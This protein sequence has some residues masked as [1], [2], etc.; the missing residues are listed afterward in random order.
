MEKLAITQSD[1]EAVSE[2]ILGGRTEISLPPPISLTYRILVF[3]FVFVLPLLAVFGILIWVGV[4]NREPR[5]RH[6][7]IQHMFGLLI[8]S[9]L[10][11]SISAVFVL[12]TMRT[13]QV[14][15]HPKPEPFELDT[16]TKFPEF[17]TMKDLSIEE[18]VRKMEPVVLIV[19]SEL[20]G[21]N[22][23]RKSLDEGGFGAGILLLANKAE[24]LVATCRHV[25]DGDR[26][27]TQRSD[28]E[29]LF[30]FGRGGGLTSA[31][32]VAR[33]KTLDLALLSMTRRR[34][35]SIFVQP[36]CNRDQIALGGR[37]VVFGHPQGMF[38]SISD[39]LVSRME[40][41]SVIQISAP[42]SPGASGGP[43]FDLKGR[44]LGIITSSIDKTSYPQAENIN[45]AIRADAMLQP[46]QWDF[47]KGGSSLLADYQTSTSK[48]S[49]RPKQENNMSLP[50]TPN[51]DKPKPN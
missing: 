1:V 37:I 32:V 6:A 36:I 48:T 45:F 49:A 29:T 19:A 23:S 3:P 31:D 24:Y 35:D 25:V 44:L 38:Y 43:V 12:L 10:I 5:I 46:Q 41:N 33:H 8:A 40:G 15:E 18:L 30:V 14:A 17:S 11:T 39:G 51:T 13:V 47:F 22:P 21:R 27:Q 28:K 26:W 4:R 20:P 50:T 34:G 16:V 42:I 7:W 2:S 9:A